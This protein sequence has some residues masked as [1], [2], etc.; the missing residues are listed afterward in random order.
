MNGIYQKPTVDFILKGERS[1]TLPPNS[2]V[3]QVCQLFI[4]YIQHYTR[5]SKTVQSGKKNE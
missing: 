3:R 1:N 4:I 5:G 2:G